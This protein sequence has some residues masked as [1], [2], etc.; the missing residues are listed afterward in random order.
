QPFEVQ[1]NLICSYFKLFN[2]RLG[3]REAQINRSWAHDIFPCK[4][5][6]FDVNITKS[7]ADF[8][9][10]QSNRNLDLVWREGKRFSTRRK[11]DL[12]LNS[13]AVVL[14][15]DR[16]GLHRYQAT[17]FLRRT[18]NRNTFRLNRCFADLLTGRRFVD[19]TR[20]HRQHPLDH[21]FPTV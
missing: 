17:Y 18:E 5:L 7:P 3:T 15:V 16:Q 4:P 11:P 10:L 14:E 20:R 6:R 9:F 2:D 8:F 21:R 19:K 13:A 1:I 12:T